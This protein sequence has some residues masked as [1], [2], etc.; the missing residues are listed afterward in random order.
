[1][2][3]A[4]CLTVPLKTKHLLASKVP[5][6]W[7]AQAVDAHALSIN[8]QPTFLPEELLIIESPWKY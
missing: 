8:N 7:C 4:T 2:A 3:H 6:P 5:P 1:L